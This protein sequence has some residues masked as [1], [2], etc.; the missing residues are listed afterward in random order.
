MER[1]ANKWVLETMGVERSLLDSIKRRKL[2]YFGHLMRKSGECLEKEIIQGN[3]PGARTRGRPRMGWL[4]NIGTWMGSTLGQTLVDT[5]D[6]KRWRKL[7][8]DATNPRIEDG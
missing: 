3:V 7:V 4:V 6:R 5:R 8:H 1:K 2:A